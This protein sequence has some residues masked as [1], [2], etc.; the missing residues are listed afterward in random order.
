MTKT[1]IVG[2]AAS[3]I[4]IV[5]A[6]SAAL[7]QTTTPSGGYYGATGSTTNMNSSGSHVG[8]PN[9]GA[10]GNAAENVAVLGVSAAI[11]TIGAIALAK[12]R[13]V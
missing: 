5:F 4:A 2:I 9:T 11:A 10:G 12:R 7:A 13:I 8:A 1:K 3:T 6:A